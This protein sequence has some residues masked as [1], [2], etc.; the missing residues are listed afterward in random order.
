MK[1]EPSELKSARDRLA[2][3][4]GQIGG[5]VRM[6]DEGRDCTDILTQLSAASTA[7]T[8]AGFSIISTGMAHCAA[9][10]E[11]TDNRGA[12]EKAFMSLA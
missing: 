11:G 12:L 5:L 1:I 2:R 8:R 10:P 3:I 7:L 6:I 9:D 4:Q